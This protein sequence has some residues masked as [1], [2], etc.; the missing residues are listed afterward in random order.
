VVN[1]TDRAEDPLQKSDGFQPLRTRVGA[2]Y[3][4]DCL[5]IAVTWRRNYIATGDAKKGNSFQ[6]HFAL[7]NLGFR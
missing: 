2:A 7:R 3:Q 1:L 4:D 5:E 6:V